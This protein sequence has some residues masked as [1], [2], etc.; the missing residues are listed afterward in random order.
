MWLEYV[1]GFFYTIINFVFAFATKTKKGGGVQ[2]SC[3]DM[4]SN[5]FYFALGKLFP[6]FVFL[7][8]SSYQWNPI[9]KVFVNHQNSKAL[10]IFNLSF[11]VFLIIF[12]VTQ[13]VRLSLLQD[14]NSVTHLV[15]FGLGPLAATICFYICLIESESFY[16]GINCVIVFL[17]H[18]NGKLT[19]F[20][21]T[22]FLMNKNNGKDLF[23]KNFNRVTIQIQ[24]TLLKFLTTLHSHCFS[25]FY[26]WV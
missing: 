19:Y 20:H 25:H 24:I 9:A 8:I 11:L 12:Y 1:I 26:R 23:Q 4:F 15:A 17:R 3:K 13:L 2:R 14:Q 6:L 10:I 16:F 22:S 18:V 5:R 21:T 7:G